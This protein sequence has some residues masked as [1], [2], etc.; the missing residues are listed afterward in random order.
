ME[1]VPNSRERDEWLS[2]GGIQ[3]ESWELGIRYI[4]GI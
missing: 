2:F 4:E 1:Q 3:H